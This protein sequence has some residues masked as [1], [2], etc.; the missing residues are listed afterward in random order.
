MSIDPITVEIIKGALKAAGR[1]MGL[2]VERTSMS[3]FIREKKDFFVGIYDGQG[4]LVYTD[5]DK[6]GMAMLDSVL[7]QYPAETMQPGDVYW[8]SDCYLSGG[9]LSHSPDMC[10]VAP[11]FLNGMLVGFAAAFGHFWDIGGMKPGT[12]SPL[13]TEIFQ[14]GLAIPPVK[15][16]D[17]DTFNDEVY[18]LILRNSRFP[19]LLQG[20]TKAM[21]AACHLGQQRLLELAQRYGQDLLHHGFEA[22]FSQSEQAVRR[23]LNALPDGSYDF[24][25]YVD[26]DCVSDTPFRVRVQL[27]VS[28]DTARVD[29]RESDDQAQGPINFLLHPDNA[30]TLIARALCWADPNVLLNHGSCRPITDVYL[31]PGSLLQPR[32]PAALGLRA[33]TMY[34][35]L[36]STLGTL[37]QANVGHTPA[38]S[39]DYVLYMLRSLDPATGR[40]TLLI[41]GIGVGQGARPFG[42]GLDVIYS[43]RG[44]KNFPMEFVEHEFPVEIL[45]YAIHCDS[46]GP[47]KFRGGAGVI[48]DVRVLAPSVTL[49][50]RM[51][52]L[53]SPSWGVKG[54]GSGAIGR[55][56][57][58]PDTP[59]ARDIPPFGDNI[60]LQQ[61]DM[62]RIMTSGGGG[63]GNPAERDPLDVLQDVKDGFVSVA[64]GREDYG[65]VIEPETWKIDWRQTQECRRTMTANPP[66]FDRGPSF[67]Q[68]EQQRVGAFGHA[69]DA[70]GR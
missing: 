28:G 3:A 63:W 46:G 50:T 34:R 37:A 4:H 12:L 15:I 23:A 1:E 7:A 69:P 6:F 53:K 61:G 30:R 62:L 36:N 47:G 58:H 26:N 68:L 31:R 9:A 35:V 42:D 57:L 32:H 66:M 17:R 59:Q 14:E 54:G 38:G 52:N 67:E 56:I 19:D 18:R 2:L 24:T 70:A 22:I 13:A 33:H 45:T 39:G 21:I 25:D 29:F 48:R 20:D 44:Q 27:Q 41:D 65:V 5:H 16:V 8:F 60:E 64:R 43:S 40:F 49:G 10:F 51:N 55:I 11:T